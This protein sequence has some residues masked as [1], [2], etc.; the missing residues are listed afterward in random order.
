MPVTDIRGRIYNMIAG[1]I[2]VP[3]W[4]LGVLLY[5]YDC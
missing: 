5:Q 3:I 2:I 1:G 4:L